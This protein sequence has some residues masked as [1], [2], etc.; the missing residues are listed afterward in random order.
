MDCSLFPPRV[1]PGICRIRPAS[2]PGRKSF[3]AT[4]PDISFCVFM[5]CCSS[6]IFVLRVNV[7]FCCVGFSFFGTS[8]ENGWEES[9][10]N[11]LF[12]VEWDV[13]A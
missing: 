5:L 4:K 3:E 8:Q 9:L 10:R 11:D 1:V 12:C 2:F 7:C 13:K 6:S